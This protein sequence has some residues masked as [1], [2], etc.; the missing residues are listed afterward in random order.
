MQKKQHIDSKNST[1]S[2][3]KK[4]KMNSNLNNVTALYRYNVKTKKIIYISSEIE[5][6]TGYTSNEIDNIGFE[7]IIL[8]KK[9]ISDAKKHTNDA[10]KNF[11]ISSSKFL[12]KTKNGKE[13]WISDKH[14]YEYDGK[15]IKSYRTGILTESS[16]TQISAD[17]MF[18]ESSYFHKILDLTDVTILVLDRNGDVSFINQAGCKLLNY[19]YSDIIGKNWFMN[20]LPKESG[21]ELKS[22]Y[23]KIFNEELEFPESNENPILPNS[24]EE[25]FLRWKSSYLRDENNKL[26]GIVSSGLDVTE[27]IKD[28]KIQQII[29]SIL[30][31]ANYESN[32][33]DFFK[34]IHSSVGELMPVENFYISLYDKENKMITFPY[35]VDQV[36]DAF[37]P[38]KFGK[39]LTEYV[40]KTGEPMLV[41]RAKDEELVRKGE[42][43]LV[44]SPTSIW[45]GIPLKIQD[46]TIGALVVQDYNAVGTYGEKEQK[47]LEMISYAISRAIERKRVEQERAELIDELK[48]LNSSK[49]K[50]ISLISHD[51]RSPFN[52]LLGFSEILTTEYDTLTHDEI[53]EY[54]KVIYEASNNLYG[55]TNNLL[56][57]SRIQMGRFDFKPKNLKL[58]KII[59]R[60]L[61]LLKGN[62]LKKQI[63]LSLNIDKNLEV[64]ADEDMLNSIIQNLTSNAIKFTNRNGDVDIIAKEIIQ[65]TGKN[66]AEI[67][68]K[69]NG[70]GINQEDLEKIKKDFIFSTPGTEREYGTGLG[71]VLVKEFIEKN[72][73]KVWINSK[74]NEGTTF[75]FTLPRAE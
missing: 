57:Y 69:D 15:G 64:F 3:T 12:I 14:I 31:A 59:N 58:I 55:M 68:I 28:E 8:S 42:V 67:T 32:L 65:A 74:V 6:I 22:K 63:H 62:L 25:R 19:E 21:K 1:L 66:F 45:L 75:T 33:N 9:N 54:L 39:G 72:K 70:I 11:Y 7:N 47:I 10:T 71:L 56:H 46:N 34:F 17:N 40:L 73:G 30:Q 35:F 60:C 16:G 53:H 24:G 29:Y 52:S 23:L 61:N 2:V 13:K 18:L 36:D 44:G 43:E 50:L 51:L 5:N 48:E 49:D 4:T 20:F 26:I 41:D 38:K 37:P 27:I